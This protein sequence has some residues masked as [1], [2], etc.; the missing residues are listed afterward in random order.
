[1]MLMNLEKLKKILIKKI[2]MKPFLIFVSLII[3]SF[4]ILFSANLVSAEEEWKIQ[5]F[6]KFSYATVS[7]EIQHGDKLAFII[8]SEDDC[9]EVTSWFTFYTWQN[10]KDFDQLL[11]KEVPILMNEEI[12][13]SATIISI[14]PFLNGNRVILALGTFPIKEY[15]YLVHKTYEEFK[16]YEIEI[17]DGINFKA[18][19]YFDI[20]V[21][22]WKLDNLVPSV[23]EAYRKCNQLLLSKS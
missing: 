21:N 10:P 14:T 17:V 1:M 22:N 18:S 11:D 4:I 5:R 20:K 23:L 19:K 6:E 7:G 16:K 9:N 8:A 2:K 13:I 15:I 3:G 12:E